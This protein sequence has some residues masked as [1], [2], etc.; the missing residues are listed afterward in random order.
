MDKED[1]FKNAEAG[2]P[3]GASSK[4]INEVWRAFIQQL[5]EN[6]TL[7][8][9]AVQAA[10]QKQVEIMANLSAEDAE[11]VLQAPRGD[12]RF[13][14]EQWRSNP[15]FSLLMQNYLLNSDTLRT[16]A[17]QATMPEK[18]KKILQ[19]AVNQYIDAMSPTN[20]PATNP[21][22]M[23]EAIKTGGES[24]AQGMQNFLRDAK[25]GNMVKNTDLSAFSVGEN[26]ATTP[27]RW[28]CKRPSCN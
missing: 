21:E 1:F 22:V 11:P 5:L 16:L 2:I 9:A 27:A 10:Q 15:V 7:W 26:I 19:F 20:F 3:G 6:P 18:D 12:R 24:L 23:E 28:C 8:L 25:S 13:A 4:K 17:A 14:A